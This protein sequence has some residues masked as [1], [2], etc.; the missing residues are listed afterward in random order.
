[1]FV[2]YSKNAKQD[3]IKAYHILFWHLFQ[4]KEVVVGDDHSKRLPDLYTEDLEIGVEVVSCE[5][6]TTYLV[7]DY[8]RDAKHITPES[9]QA[10]KSAQRKFNSL[11]L[12]N[13]H[14]LFNA[15]FEENIAK[16]LRKIDNYAGV[17]SR[18]L[19][20]ISDA[21]QKNYIRRSKLIEIYNKCCKEAG[22]KFDGLY[23]FYNKKLYQLFDNEFKEI[24]TK[25]YV[26]EPLTNNK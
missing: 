26:S 22:R 4:D 24:K 3:E 10:V 25:Y 8:I 7:D 21:E 2:K 6:F 9:L 14:L 11:S 23:L 20:V 5:Q 18:Y 1:M 12:K 15:I 17:E 16:K 19:F 13:K